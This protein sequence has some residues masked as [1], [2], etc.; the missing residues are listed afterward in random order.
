MNSL[1]TENYNIYLKNKNALLGVFH[2]NHQINQPDYQFAKSMQDAVGTGFGSRKICECVGINFYD[3][4]QAL[5]LKHLQAL[6]LD[7]VSKAADVIS[8]N[9]LT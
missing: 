1:S 7:Q 2:E 6:M 5:N 3:G 8:D 4:Y 9:I